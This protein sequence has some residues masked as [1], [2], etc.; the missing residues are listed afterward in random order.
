[1]AKR[2]ITRVY[3]RTGDDGKTALIGGERTRKSSPR[4]EAYGE[5]DEL[6]SAVGAAARA[7]RDPRAGKILLD[8]QNALFVLGSDLATPGDA[9]F[10]VPR[11]TERMC[12]DLEKLIDGFAA[13]LGDL[14]EFILPG[15]SEGAASLH[16]ARAVC[17]RAER[18]TEALFGDSPGG[19]NVLVY[20]NRLSDLLFVMARAENRA[21]G[22]GEVFADFGGGG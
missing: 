12:G 21:A 10:S 14:R 6:N 17:R 3:T 18:R 9:G 7:A 1:M 19:R 4:V 15:G 2:R 22:T 13:E 11:V 8:V 16:L 20:L 5:V